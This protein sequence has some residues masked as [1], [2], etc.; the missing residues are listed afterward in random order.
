[1]TSINHFIKHLI[2]GLSR[3][4]IILKPQNETVNVFHF[5]QRFYSLPLKCGDAKCHPRRSRENGHHL[6]GT[7]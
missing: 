2:C 1:M 7:I 5:P 3:K 6:K 4:F